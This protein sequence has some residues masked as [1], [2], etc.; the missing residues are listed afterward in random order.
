MAAEAVL[1]SLRAKKKAPVRTLRSRN[2]PRLRLAVTRDHTEDRLFSPACT[3]AALIELAAD[4]RFVHFD[5]PGQWHFVR[6]LN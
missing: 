6:S 4:V 5:R 3:L 2:M 1:G